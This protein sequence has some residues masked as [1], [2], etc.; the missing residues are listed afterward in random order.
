MRVVE[1]EITLQ[2]AVVAE[3]ITSANFRANS[4]FFT[5][6]STTEGHLFGVKFIGL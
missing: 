3:L 5:S 2:A 4:S 6:L 1:D